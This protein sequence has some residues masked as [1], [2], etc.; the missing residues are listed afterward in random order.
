[1]RVVDLAQAIDVVQKIQH[2]NGLSWFDGGET[3]QPAYSSA[4]QI[5]VVFHLGDMGAISSISCRLQAAN[6]AR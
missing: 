2:G 5:G 1:M 3:R 4:P 6:S